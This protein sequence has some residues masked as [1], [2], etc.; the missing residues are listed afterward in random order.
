MARFKIPSAFMLHGQT[1]KVKRVNHIITENNTLGEAHLGRNF[2][3]LQNSIE[4]R[5]LT[6]EQIEQTFIHELVHMI[7]FHAG[8][9]ELTVDE[10]FVELVSNLLH[11][12]LTTSIYDKEK[13]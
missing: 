8:Q 11:Q 9:E 10:A 4:G 6:T 3:Y 1:I 13:K 5:K 2:I 7:L 12:A